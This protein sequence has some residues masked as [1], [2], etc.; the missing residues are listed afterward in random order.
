MKGISIVI[1]I[2]RLQKAQALSDRMAIKS[3]CLIKTSQQG[4]LT[5][6]PMDLEIEI[7]RSWYLN[8]T[9]IPEVLEV[10]GMIKNTDRCLKKISRNPFLKYK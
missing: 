10:L 4:N 2:I 3:F 5:K 6:F 8:T 9:L 1:I 7:A